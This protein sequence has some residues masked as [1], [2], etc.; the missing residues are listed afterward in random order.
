MM[1]K[2]I[3]SLSKVKYPIKHKPFYQI[4]PYGG[5]YFNCW[6]CVE[7]NTLILMGNGSIKPIRNLKINDEIIGIKKN[8]NDTR[9]IYTKTRVL[10]HWKTEKTGYKINLE[11]GN[12][13]T[14]SAD[15]RLLT[16]RGWKFITGSE[17]GK[18]RRPFLTSKNFLRGI[19]KMS[20]TLPITKKL[21]IEGL[22][23][24]NRIKIKEII[25]L[26]KKIDM[27]D[28]TTGTGNYIANGIISHNCYNKFMIWIDK[29]N[30]DKP[31]PILNAH[32]L[33]EKEIK[34]KQPGTIMISFMTD[35]YQPLEKEH[36]I[37]KK[38]LEVILKHVK[39]GWHVILL[40]K[41][42]LILRDLELIKKFGDNIEIG[43]TI[44]TNEPISDLHVHP[45]KLIEI[46][47]IFHENGVKTFLSIEPIHEKTQILEILK[48]TNKYCDKYI[49]G[50]LNYFKDKKKD[51]EAL[52]TELKQF[53]S[54]SCGTNNIVHLKEKLIDYIDKTS[55]YSI[56]N[57]GKGEILEIR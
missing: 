54:D 8:N 50:S 23:V 4:T 42:D 1:R 47:K 48:K 45:D 28:I 21:Q 32:V 5:C 57:E 55:K 56:T 6:F 18:N 19:G 24:K 27:F 11:G 31:Q 12:F 10:N 14:C 39:N 37:T 13:I 35:C 7:G 43:F 15:H 52:V 29:E 30:W 25:P 2:S 9:Y 16:H 17:Q 40:T 44:V 36:E 33:L 34:K 3:L 49:L 51:V 20:E 26:N 53:L 38:C 46:L 41:S 22:I